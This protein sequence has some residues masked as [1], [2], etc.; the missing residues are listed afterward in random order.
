MYKNNKW[1]KKKEQRK[2]ITNNKNIIE[3]NPVRET[4]TSAAEEWNQRADCPQANATLAKATT[5]GSTHT[6]KRLHSVAGGATK[7]EVKTLRRHKKVYKNIHTCRNSVFPWTK[8]KQ[9]SDNNI[10]PL[11]NVYNFLH[12]CWWIPGKLHKSHKLQEAE[13]LLR[14][15]SYSYAM[16]YK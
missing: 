7:D 8:A 6:L 9:K 16:A 15:V 14:S 3:K 4:I 1:R 10:H 11:C 13:Y 2:I 5:M 12:V